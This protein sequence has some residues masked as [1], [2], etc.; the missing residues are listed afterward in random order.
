MIIKVNNKTI[1]VEGLILPDKEDI[2]RGQLGLLNIDI[3]NYNNYLS[4]TSNDSLS[5]SYIHE[6]IY[7]LYHNTLYVLKN[8]ECTGLNTRYMHGIANFDDYEI[9]DMKDVLKYF[10]ENDLTINNSINNVNKYNL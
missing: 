9:L 2:K 7:C 10:N 8:F 5:S 6:K 3:Q 1:Q 4:P